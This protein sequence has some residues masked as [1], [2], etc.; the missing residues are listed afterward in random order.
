M[1]AAISVATS[2]DWKIFRWSRL[3]LIC[4]PLGDTIRTRVHEFS[5][6][7]W[8]GGRHNC[9]LSDNWPEKSARVW[10]GTDVGEKIQLPGQEVQYTWHAFP[11]ACT[12]NTKNE[13]EKVLNGV[14]PDFFFFESSIHVDVQRH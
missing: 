3:T 7:V 12:I 6:S 10:N 5:D 11:S 13:I 1:Q 4:D 14:R 8:C 9:S 2:Q